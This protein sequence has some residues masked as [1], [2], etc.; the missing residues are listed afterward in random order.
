MTQPQNP[1]YVV[2]RGAEM[3]FF[4]DVDPDVAA[5]RLADAA[6]HSYATFNSAV[7]DPCWSDPSDRHGHHGDVP[8]TYL[9]CANDQGIPE[10]LQRRMIA[11]TTDIGGARWR[12]WKCSAGH[13]P[14]TSQA[15]TVSVAVRKIAGE[16]VGSVPGVEISEED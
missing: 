7:Q 6:P 8:L 16:Y 13:N 9:I 2:I 1:D 11:K 10:T 3:A 14:A 4:S 5:S 12:V 15:E